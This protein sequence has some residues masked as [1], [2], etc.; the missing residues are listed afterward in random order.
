[1]N[2]SD[3]KALYE[4]KHKYG[5]SLKTIA[6]SNSLKY[7]LFNNKGLFKLINDINGQ[8]RNPFRMLQ[9]NKICEFYNIKL[10]ETKS[11]TY[12]NGWFSGFI[13]SD[14]SIYIDEKTGLLTISVAQKNKY[15]L[16]PL[17]FLYSG[18]INILKNKEEFQYTIYKKKEILNL[19]D[20]YLKFYPLRSGKTNKIAL[21]KDFYLL[22]PSPNFFKLNVSSLQKSD[23]NIFRQ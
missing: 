7:K 14:G 3:K 12:Y 22:M 17:V 23:I 10:E 20:N 16:E 9:L 13:D 1:M 5:G 19:I 21:I 11:L 8:I 6:G 2:I 15:L 4:I 18:K